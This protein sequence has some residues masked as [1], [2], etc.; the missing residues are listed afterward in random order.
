MGQLCMACVA[1]V[2]W[3]TGEWQQAMS[4]C[5]EVIASTEVPIIRALGQAFLSIIHVYR[6]E[7]KQARKLILAALTQ[8]RRQEAMMMEFSGEA[9]LAL[10]DEL[11]GDYDSAIEELDKHL[12]TPGAYWSIEGLLPD[13]RLDPIRNDPRFQAMVERYRRQ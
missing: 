13:P 5:R 9:N 10:I 8:A 7:T 11:E 2:M 3:Q 4:L 12:A 6:G 1:G